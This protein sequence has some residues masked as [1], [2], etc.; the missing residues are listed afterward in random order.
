MCP[1]LLND[2]KDYKANS[3]SSSR[4]ANSK[5]EIWVAFRFTFGANPA[6]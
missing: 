1:F 2:K 3:W 5:V 6:S 4:L